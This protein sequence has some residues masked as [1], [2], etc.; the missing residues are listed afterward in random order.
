MMR[1]APSLVARDLLQMQSD[2]I[3]ARVLDRESQIVRWMLGITV[4]VRQAS[5]W[6]VRR[7]IRDLWE[8][9]RDWIEVFIFGARFYATCAALPKVLLYFGFA[10]G[11]DLLCTA[12]MR[13]LRQRGRGG[14]LM[15]SDHSE[16]FIAN[17]DPAYVRPLWRR[18][19]HGPVDRFDLSAL[20]ENLG[21]IPKT[22]RRVFLTT[23]RLAVRDFP[24][25]PTTFCVKDIRPLS[26]HQ[27]KVFSCLAKI[28]GPF[29]GQPNPS[30]FPHDGTGRIGA[31]DH[32]HLGA[33]GKVV[34]TVEVAR[35]ATYVEVIGVRSEW[36]GIDRHRDREGIRA[37]QIRPIAVLKISL[38]RQQARAA[39]TGE[40]NPD[41]DRRY[42][43]RRTEANAGFDRLTMSQW[44]SGDPFNR[45]HAE[46]VALSSVSRHPV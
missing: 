15:V 26:P 23:A 21:L 34:Q 33:G 8:D 40:A 10:P 24:A 39:G 7:T 45:F 16:L 19:Y 36:Q 35:T 13:E 1:K 42:R 27:L 18:D 4:F 3:W 14:L 38:I 44:Q 25:K 11:D 20:C 32:L 17:G 43:S 5:P 22:K 41:S 6:W 29:A 2:R 30:P 46:P 31:G 28:P 37:R 12:V 9:L